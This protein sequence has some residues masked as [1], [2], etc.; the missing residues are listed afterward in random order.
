MSMIEKATS[1]RPS[2]RL[3]A[4]VL[5]IILQG[6]C[7]RLP[8]SRECQQVDQFDRAV[9]MLESG[10]DEEGLA[11]V[12][13]LASSGDRR[14]MSMIAD[15]D[16]NSEDAV[17]AGIARRY[18]LELAHSGDEFWVRQIILESLRAERSTP[19]GEL[20]C[21]LAPDLTEENL[22]SAARAI[23]ARPGE[24]PLTREA[25]VIAHA[26]LSADS[27]EP[28]RGTDFNDI[29]SQSSP[30]FDWRAALLESC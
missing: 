21:A 19:I 23:P 1:L 13:A 11:T 9:C 15:L 4:V 28:T 14:A 10:Q 22:N 7:E 5:I 24:Q 26:L 3:L 17:Q 6:S 2:W 8:Q 29:V 25:A 12:R 30:W 20:R 16:R 27:P 18:A